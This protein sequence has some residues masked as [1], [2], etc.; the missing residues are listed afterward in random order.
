MSEDDNNPN[1]ITTELCQ[2]YRDAIMTEVKSIKNTIIAS[3]S[4]STAIITL[5]VYVITMVTK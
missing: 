1:G 3:L 5:V 2:A 4:I